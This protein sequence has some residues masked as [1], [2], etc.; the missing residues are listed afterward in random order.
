MDKHTLDLNVFEAFEAWQDS[1]DANS[2]LR[3]RP[4]VATH[5]IE[6]T[7]HG[8]L[9]WSEYAYDDAEADKLRDDAIN[10]GFNCLLIE[11]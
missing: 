11:L 8:E 9:Q 2:L 10:S 7:L 1:L 3:I 6:A 4:A 5:Y